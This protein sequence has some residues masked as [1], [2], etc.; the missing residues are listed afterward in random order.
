MTHP[1]THLWPN[2]GKSSAKSMQKLDHRLEELK[3]AWPENRLKKFGIN[4]NR[5]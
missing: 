3:P 2:F 4:G 1:D 5:G